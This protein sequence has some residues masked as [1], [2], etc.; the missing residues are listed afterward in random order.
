VEAKASGRG[1]TNWKQCMPLNRGEKKF[2]EFRENAYLPECRSARH[3]LEEETPLWGPSF[4]PVCR[5]LAVATGTLGFAAFEKFCFKAE[6]A[7]VSLDHH[8]IVRSQP[9]FRFLGI[10]LSVSN[11]FG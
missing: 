4:R 7:A 11:I 5:A 1:D 9:I 6:V 10:N 8:L 2:L 3:P